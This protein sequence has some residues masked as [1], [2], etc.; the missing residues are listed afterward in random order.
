MK[1]FEYYL[2][3]GVVKKVSKD[4][5]L[6]KSLLKDIEIRM[7]QINKL[8]KKDFAKII[9]ENIYDSIRDFC[10]SL[11]ALEGYKSY[12]HQASI[13]FLK[14]YGV[15]NALITKIDIARNLRNESKYYG[16][17]IKKTDVKTI[18]EIYN[19]LQNKINEVKKS[20][21]K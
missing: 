20:L 17:E 16:E 3:K 11:L 1:E 2:K 4:I 21:I 15:D 6:A 8:N 19:K 9:Y 10:D 14:K 5:N 18:Q 7:K 12:S 13:I